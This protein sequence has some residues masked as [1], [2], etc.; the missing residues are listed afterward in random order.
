MNRLLRLS[1][2]MA[3]LIAIH[4]CEFKKNISRDEIPNIKETIVALEIAIKARHLTY[5]DSLLSSDAAEAGTTAQSILDFVYSDGLTEFVGFTE[6]QIFFRGNAARIDCKITGPDGPTKDVTI[7]M[8][9]QGEV[10]F[11]KRI[12]SKVDDALKDDSLET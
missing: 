2:I 6:K 10:W 11:V 8:R 9:K 3:G 7:T 5:L 4:G 12:E 1:I